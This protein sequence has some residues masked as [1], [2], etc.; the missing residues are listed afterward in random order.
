MA[1]VSAG[2]RQADGP[3]GG[4]DVGGRRQEREHPLD[5]QHVGKPAAHPQ[6]CNG[7]HEQRR[8]PPWQG[9]PPGEQVLR[10]V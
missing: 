3:G 6:Q 10:G 4:A 7:G 5:D 8:P 1:T 9:N 2:S